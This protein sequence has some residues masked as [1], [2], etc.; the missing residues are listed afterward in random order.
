[1]AALGLAFF[2]LGR[3]IPSRAA[4]MGLARVG[5]AIPATRR[6]R[7]TVTARAA[8]VCLGA[9]ALLL[10]GGDWGDLHTPLVAG[11]DA[12]LVLAFARDSA[13]AWTRLPAAI[14]A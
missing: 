5:L 13:R 11:L 9:F 10:T 12:L 14:A 2:A 3:A 4:R 1:V 6:P 8:A 7:L